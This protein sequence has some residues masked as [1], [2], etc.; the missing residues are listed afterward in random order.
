MNLS[1]LWSREP[2]AIVNAV[3]LVALAAM[4]FGLKLTAEQLMASMVALEAVLTLFTRNQVTSPASLQDMTPRTLADAQ[5]TAGPVRDTAKKLPVVLLAC[6][7]CSSISCASL[8]LK[9]KAVIG[10]QSSETALEGA[11]N[12]ERSICFVAP[13]TE[14]GGHCTNPQA[15]AMKLTDATHQKLASIFAKAF[16]AEIKGAIALK[17]W[18]AGDPPPSDVLSYHQDITEA[19]AVAKTLD[20]AAAD[21]IAKIQAA[22]DSGAAVLL[23]LGVK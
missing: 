16:A 12:I 10:L 22:V 8:P 11:H 15:A 3:R 7:L 2:V 1:A 20:P 5:N 13:A 23:A 18:K 21:I 14:S 6:V 9:Q 19:L 17:G 4:T